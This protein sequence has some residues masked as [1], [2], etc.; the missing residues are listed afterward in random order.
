MLTR[1]LVPTKRLRDSLSVLRPLFPKGSKTVPVGLNVENGELTITCTQG[2]IYQDSIEIDDLNA[3]EHVTV[4]YFDITSLLYED[5]ETALE[6]GQVAVSLSNSA[7]EVSLHFGYSVVSPVTFELPEFRTIESTIYVDSIKTLAAMNLNKLYNT[8]APLVFENTVVLQK[9]PN[10]WVQMK[11]DGFGVRATID[12]D[13][14]KLLNVFAP[15]EIAVAK[16]STLLFR[17]DNTLLQIPYKVNTDSKKI[18]NLL[19]GMK[20]Q[21]TVNPG[22][23]LERL[24][25]ISKVD[26]KAHAQITVYT[27]GIKTTVTA[28]SVNLSASAGESLTDVVSVFHYPI[29]VWIAFLKALGSNYIEI[30]TG[31][32][33]ICL[34][35]SVTVIVTRVLP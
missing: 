5:D 13:H 6:F 1:I 21:C 17:K 22:K 30:L 31:G 3:T 2:I 33:K 35:S 24:M 34:R 28:E 15:K 10:T 18:T 4:L 7:F 29:L 23:Y 20:V 16:G 27:G 19:D 26:S 8:V 32:E 14:A 25:S 11:A 9:Y 12:V